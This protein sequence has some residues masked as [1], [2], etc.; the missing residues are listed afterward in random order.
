MNILLVTDWGGVVM[1]V[2]VYNTS[3]TTE[4][5]SRHEERQQYQRNSAPP[6]SSHILHILSNKL[7]LIIF[8]LCRKCSYWAPARTTMKHHMI[9]TIIS[10]IQGESA[11]L[12]FIVS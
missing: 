3:V 6:Y 2:N 4:N 5:L 12:P 7:Y 10:N 9:P 11:R 1:A 8:I